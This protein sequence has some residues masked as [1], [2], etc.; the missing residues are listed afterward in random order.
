MF[1]EGVFEAFPQK[2]WNVYW[3]HHTQHVPHKDFK[4]AEVKHN[5]ERCWEVTEIQGDPEWEQITKPEAVNCMSLHHKNTHH[6]QQASYEEVI[7]TMSPLK[8]LRDIHGINEKA[9]KALEG[10][11]L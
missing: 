9:R 3:T 7:D 8:K 5:E 6:L 4:K 10:E 1:N 11:P 2:G